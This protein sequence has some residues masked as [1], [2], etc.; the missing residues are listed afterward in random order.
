MSSGYYEG[1]GDSASF[2]VS[3]GLGWLKGDA[4]FDS[5]PTWE[6]SQAVNFSVIKAVDVAENHLRRHR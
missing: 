2:Y 3:E 4:P 1:N 6:F 5:M